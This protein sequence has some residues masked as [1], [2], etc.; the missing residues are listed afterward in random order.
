MAI[1]ALRQSFVRRT[2]RSRTFP[3]HDPVFSRA[4]AGERHSDCSALADLWGFEKGAVIACTCGC[5]SPGAGDRAIVAE[6]ERRDRERLEIKQ[7]YPVRVRTRA[8]WRAWLEENH[9]REPAACLMNGGR[10]ELTFQDATD[11]ALCF[12]WVP[13]SVDVTDRSQV[14]QP[15]P[16]G[17]YWEPYH[18]ARYSELLRAGL[19]TDAGVAAGPETEDPPA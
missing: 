5:H 18:R 8:E 1:A 11:E 10:R 2:Y 6:L 15:R 3:A 9:D 14:F 4:C 12:G 19:V 17:S 13:E 7:R 16:K